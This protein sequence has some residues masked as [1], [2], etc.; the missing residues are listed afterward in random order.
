MENLITIV[1][2]EDDGQF[3]TRLKNVVEFDGDIKIVRRFEK[4]EDKCLEELKT[5]QPKMVILDIEPPLGSSYDGIEA[6]EKIKQTLE[7]KGCKILILS[8]H[9]DEFKICSALINGADG[10]ADKADRKNI[11]NAIRDVHKG[12]NV[13]SKSVQK[14][15]PKIVLSLIGSDNMDDFNKVLTD[16]ERIVW[17]ARQQG[18]SNS[19]I[20]DKMDITVDGVK[21]HVNKINKKIKEYKASHS[22]LWDKIKNFLTKKTKNTLN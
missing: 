13:F 17:A 18:L 8:S 9:I 4:F 19:A 1:L 6:A 12:D 15:L 10:Y 5:L 20:A 21:F 14:K 16:K 3:A 22:S 7:L 2:F 11:I